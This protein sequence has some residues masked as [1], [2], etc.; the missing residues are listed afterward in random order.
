VELNNSIFP[1]ARG[2][3]RKTAVA[4]QRLAEAFRNKREIEVH[5]SESSAGMSLV[6]QFGSKFFNPEPQGQPVV[7]NDAQLLTNN[8]GI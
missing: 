6:L 5:H 8:A 2:N 3:S 4:Q 7:G 1:A